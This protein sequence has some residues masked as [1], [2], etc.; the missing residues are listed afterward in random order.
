MNH[1]PLIRPAGPTVGAHPKRARSTLRQLAGLAVAIVVC[2]LLGCDPVPTDH[3]VVGTVYIDE[4]RVPNWPLPQV[5]DTAT[6]GVPLEITIWTVDTGCRDM[7]QGDTEVTAL[8]RSAIVIPYDILTT[9]EG[10]FLLTIND[11]GC[12][13]TLD[14]FEHKATVVFE[15]PGT[16][17]IWLLYSTLGGP[18]P[19]DNTADGQ[20]VYTV[21]VLPAG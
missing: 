4:P 5:P 10:G 16:A 15:E 17:T 19:E 7:R 12:F 3:R 11:P 14:A 2:A 20:Q 13:G 18:E 8:G 21:E 6:A 9:Y 1:A